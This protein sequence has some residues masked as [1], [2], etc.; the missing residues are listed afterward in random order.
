L[1]KKKIIIFGSTGG[2]GKEIVKLLKN[3]PYQLFLFNKKKLNFSQ[4]KSKDKIHKILKK[5]NPDIIINASG[6]LGTNK[7]DYRKIYDINLMPN[8]EIIKYYK[9][10]NLKKKIVIIL[11]GSSAYKSGRKNYILYASS[12]AALHNL[13]QGSRE[14]LRGKKITIKLLNFGKIYTSM[15]K[16]YVRQN[17]PNVISPTK[18]ALKI[19]KTFDKGI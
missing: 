18:A 3:K 2:V 5:I 15:I 6:I 19:C 8:W 14:Y 16:K 12:K 13:C 10:I 17:S 1:T 4:L 7:D 9:K 11:L